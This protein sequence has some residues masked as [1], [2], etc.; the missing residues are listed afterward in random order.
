MND[1]NL[2]RLRS[3][4]N[5]A[6]RIARGEIRTQDGSGLDTTDQNLKQYRQTS[7]QIILALSDQQLVE[8]Y[9]Q[10]AGEPG[11]IYKEALLA[12][13]ERRNLDI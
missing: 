8:S 1:S 7:D 12:E 6:G 10:T 3:L 2:N 13:I 5:T 4:L 11:E 9:Q